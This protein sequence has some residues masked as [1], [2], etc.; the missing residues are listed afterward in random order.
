MNR[1][2]AI[3][4]ASLLV[5]GAISVPSIFGLLEG[6]VPGAQ[7]AQDWKPAVLSGDELAV[8]SAIADI[9][10]PRTDSPGALDVGV[11]AFIDT[12]LNDTYEP[13]ERSNYLEGLHEFDA[14]ARRSAGK[15]FVELAPPAQR[16]LVQRF[17]DA[18]IADAR[19]AQDREREEVV[20]ELRRAQPLAQRTELQTATRRRPF[21]LLTR[22]LT[23]L[24]FFTSR[25]GATQV[26][27]YV[28]IPGAY[29][30]CLPVSQAGNGRRWAI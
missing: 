25:P 8:V 23:L 4:R 9:L 13:A 15:R 18:A 20:R 24:G 22:E 12:L 11:P 16:S 30:G 3:R 26:L 14:A 29:R 1:R 6:C 17:Q 27:Q 21:I 10:L 28:A 5:G 7:T 19:A 2:E